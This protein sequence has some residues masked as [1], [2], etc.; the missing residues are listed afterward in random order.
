MDITHNE[1]KKG[2]KNGILYV[3]QISLCKVNRGKLNFFVQT[4]NPILKPIYSEY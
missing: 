2:F 1:L 3:R 4:K